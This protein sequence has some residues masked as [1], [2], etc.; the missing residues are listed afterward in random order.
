[1]VAVAPPKNPPLC[2]LPWG[3]SLSY[4]P[5]SKQCQDYHKHLH[6]C[7]PT[8][9]YFICPCSQG[10]QSF[11]YQVS[12]PLLPQLPLRTET[13]NLLFASLY[14]A[15]HRFIF[16][17]P[18]RKEDDTDT[19]GERGWEALHGVLHINTSWFK[20]CRR[21]KSNSSLI[22]C[23][24]KISTPSRFTPFFFFLPDRK[25]PFVWV[26][27]SPLLAAD[28]KQDRKWYNSCRRECFSHARMLLR[29]PLR[30]QAEQ[31]RKKRSRHVRHRC[32]LFKIQ[33]L[34]II[35][36]V[37]STHLPVYGKTECTNESSQ[38]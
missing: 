1:M 37:T 32:L 26:G 2:Y 23:L 4:L 22:V 29:W 8:Q 9:N 24:Y 18:V 36:W 28:R 7:A 3:S 33:H 11:L 16:P 17:S 12:E 13:T 31:R 20:G 30:L 27:G 21:G 10:R 35:S 6:Y 38:D 14:L 19:G 15:V 25:G 5:P 34:G